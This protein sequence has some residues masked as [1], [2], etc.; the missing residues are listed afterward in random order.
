MNVTKAAAAL[1]PL[2]FAALLPAPAPAAQPQP[3]T[4][5]PGGLRWVADWGERR[6]TLARTAANAAPVFALRFL[7]GS[8]RLEL[9]FPD[10]PPPPGADRGAP[11]ALVFSDGT[12]VDAQLGW[13]SAGETAPRL[14]V[15]GDA[16]LLDQLARS[17]SVKLMHRGETLADVPLP[18][19]GAAIAALRRCADTALAEWGVDTAAQ[20][21]L[22]R[23]PEPAP[24]G[25]PWIR[26]DDYPRGA[27]RRGS[28]G[29]VIVRLTVNAAGRVSECAVAES[30]GD[31]ELD[32]TTCRLFVMRG[33]YAPALDAGG[34]PTAAST[35]HT[36][37]W[38]LPQ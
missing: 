15:I 37:I 24:P 14:V 29:E 26:N 5:P 30:S 4:Q 3:Q 25:P 12:R 11:A 32:A 31:A 9:L 17:T 6:C 20:A 22:Q 7:P 34:R 8:T 10:R 23:R 38:T 28:S 21:A 33:R 16:A 35:I 19:V 13:R 36:I 27:L 2:I 1:L 18:R